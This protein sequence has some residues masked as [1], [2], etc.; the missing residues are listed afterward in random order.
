L[1]SDCSDRLLADAIAGKPA[2]TVF[3]NRGDG[4]ASPIAE[5]M[6]GSWRGKPRAEIKASGYVAHT[7]EA[8]VWSVGRTPDFESAILTAA[9]LGEDAD[10]TA[11]VAGQLAG[12]LYGADAIPPAWRDRLA[13]RDRIE[14]WANKVFGESIQ[15]PHGLKEASLPQIVRKYGPDT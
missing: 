9:N 11:A 15:P 6:D 7:L 14:G 5:I 2:T 4:F 10:T 12:A 13:W 3:R 8:A 1:N